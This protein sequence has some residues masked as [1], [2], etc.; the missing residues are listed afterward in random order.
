MRPS[1]VWRDG[2]FDGS[3]PDSEKVV[4]WTLGGRR[5]CHV[6]LDSGESNASTERPGVTLCPQQ[7]SRR[8]AG[9]ARKGMEGATCSRPTI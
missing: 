6:C 8:G 3:A 7:E 2:A 5:G 4:T 1:Q 9:P